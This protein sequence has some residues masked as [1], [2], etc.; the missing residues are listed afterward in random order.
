MGKDKVYH[1]VKSPIIV[2]ALATAFS[3]F[4]LWLIE[5]WI[6][7]PL[8][9]FE[10][11][12]IIV[13]YLIVSGYDI[14][15]IVKQTRIENVNVGLI[16]DLFLMTSALSL[17]TFNVLKIDGGLVQL[18]LAL[19]C[20]S[21]LSGYAILNIFELIHYFSR[22]ETTVLSFILSYAFTAFITL[23]SLPLN[24]NTRILILLGSYIG[25]GLVS[26]LKHKRQPTA[27]SLKSF[28]KN[29]DS[30]ALM[31]S[32]AFYALS[33]CLMY[34]GFTLLPGTDISRHYASSI[35][36]GRT[37]DIYIGSAYLLSHLHESMLLSL[38]KP[39][40]VSAQTAL[41]TLNLILPLA[42]YIMVKPYLE[43]IDARLPSLATVFWVLF[44]NSL[45]GF[46]WLYFLKIKLSTL[47]QTQLQLLAT[48]ADKTYNGTVYGIL[49]LWYVPAVVSLV[50]LMAAVFLMCKKEIP[51][52]KYLILF[53]ITIAV[54]YLTHVTEAVIFALFLAVY[55]AI[56]RNQNLRVNDTI[57]S[58]I[59]GFVFVI[60][61]YYILSVLSARFIINMSLLVSLIGPISALFFSLL[62]RRIIKP[63]RFFSG[64]W[65]KIK[66]RT[67]LEIVVL[68]LIFAY[69]VAF[70]T[71]TTSAD[72]FHTWQVDAFGL[73][74]WFMYPLMLGVN[75]LLAI[76][77][78]YYLTR[79][80]K[81]YE[82]VALFLAFMIFTFVAGRIVSTINLYF[83][84][85]GYWEKRFIWLIKLS[86][87]VFAPIPILFSIDRL[88]KGN[89]H[90]N[91]KTVASV[92]IIGI[93]VLYGVST[94]FL[95]LEYWSIVANNP[96][97][98]PS[99]DE[100]KA[101]NAFKKILD[102]DPKA[103]LA[104]V[105][106]TS[107]AI[108]TFAAPADQLGLKQLLYTAYKPEMAF[109]QLY[110]HPAY[111]HAYI[112]L[113][114]RDLTRLNQLADRF[115]ANYVK[116]LPKV[117]E[118]SEVKI[119]N[120][121]KVSPPLP[122]SDTVL[123]LP[124]DKSL[125]DEQNLYTAYSLL[126]QGLYN[127]TVAYDLDDKALNSKTIVLTYDPPEGNI[128]TSLFE[129]QFNE[130][131]ASYTIVRGSW[132]I[133]SGELLGGET[134]KY[135]EGIILSPVSAENFTASFKA[136]PVNGNSS[137]LNYVSLVYSWVDSKNYRIADIMFGAD[138][139][140][141]VHFRT[142][143]N[144]VEQTIPRCPGIKT[145]IKWNFGDEYNITV[146][147][148]GTLNQIA[149]NGKTYLTTDL[150]NIP[151]RIG[152]RYYRFYQVSF[153]EF[154]LTYNVL[155]NLRP[156]EDY[157]TYLESGGKLIILNINGYNSFANN[158]FS[159]EN[160]K[161]NAE[162]IEMGKE[163]L[164][165]P[166]QIAMPKLTLK[167]STISVL[168]QYV[169]LNGETPFIVKQNFGNG[170]LFY[171]N[172][173]PIIEV[174]RKNEASTY[175]PLLG[176][177]LEN[178]SLP[179]IRPNYVLSADGYVKEI[180]LKNDVNIET[181]SLIFPLKTTLKKL[182]IKTSDE[183]ITFFNVTSIKMEDYSKL[184]VKTGNLTISD[185]QGFYA[186][187]KLNT[188]FT[189]EPCE[190]TLNL[191]IATEEAKHYITHVEQI[192]ITP[193]GA[194]HLLARTP[195]VSANEVTF[196]E[197][198]TLGSLKWQTRT[199]G[200]N[201][202][203]KGAT[204]F[205]I[206]LSDSYT[207]LE[208]VKLGKSFERNP[209]IVMFDEFSTLPT[210]VFWALLLLPIFIG[211]VLILTIERRVSTPLKKLDEP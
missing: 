117:Y 93:I 103:W 73:V 34:P 61:I 202:N 21:L 174:L 77:A 170:E 22:L 35:I 205:Q 124:L 10:A 67:F 55:G 180:Q 141:Y 121:S 4:T 41:V 78:L 143:I 31:L 49:G 111:N 156:L 59:L 194:I 209:P 210:A 123:I 128:L 207:M 162:K 192:S 56:S 52:K 173:K 110:R 181:A 51:A 96:A 197:F 74:P 37:P 14:K 95:N 80:V 79:D 47:G 75:G 137:V 82:V 136:K 63:K 32:G 101:V 20:T 104:T 48:T 190:G 129:D 39:S 196:I 142:I 160:S 195:K 201:L 81:S 84:D 178:L 122:S 76:I 54:S 88:K 151:G 108:A 168:S 175:Y 97:Y 116:M 42:F 92:A 171:V 135:G 72:S 68:S 145:D 102:N 115:L 107:A 113:H 11:L 38:S 3:S 167:N 176:S 58:S 70:L 65:S 112:Y 189:I 199:Y 127:Y 26:A 62:I 125:C 126:S 87:A 17:L 25:L 114:N 144:G 131:L 24:E 118:N 148:N 91:V 29:I 161:L 60:I 154:S 44:T 40:L 16:I 149:V 8:F 134:G 177:L 99:S 83:F 28:A 200:Q 206:I 89:I 165:L 188:T 147:V 98:Q 71:W 1:P 86:L 6:K 69:A 50:V 130:T 106:E 57:K 172:I 15:I 186:T 208:N 27:P 155:L 166:T 18:A 204:S 158:L 66:N 182:E 163:T 13:L 153:D 45:G 146:T 164:S 183:T 5:S 187:L 191:E 19:L 193:Y 53:S 120:V 138:F 133:T 159:V 7:Y 23:V 150:E 198:Y 105:T 9:L 85:A 119:Y 152:L 211:T 33:F 184:L 109:T 43:R 132:Q 90:V 30:L 100:M 140:V 36:L 169:G 185:G 139:Y 157:L 46:A 94:T 64:T 12:T 179:K 2:V 203:V